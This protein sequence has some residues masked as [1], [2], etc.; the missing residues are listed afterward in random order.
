MDYV[1][2]AVVGAGVLGCFAARALA[3]YDLRIA[4]FEERE[5]VCTGITRANTGIV[6]TGCDAR[7]GTRKARL[8]VE[9][10]RDFGALCETLG[11]R[12]S[13]CGSLMAAFGPRGAARLSRK[14][15]QGQESGVPG[16]RLL[17]P[18]EVYEMEPLLGGGVTAA[19]YAPG[20]GVVEP[21]E[22]GIA[23][24]ENARDNGVDFRFSEKIAHIERAAGGGF[25]LETDRRTCAAR[26][27][28]NC[29]GL[30]AD[31]VRELTEVP[32]IRI[33][34]TAGDYLVL[35][36]DLAGL[37]RHVVFHE[38][39]EGKGLTLVPT[40]DG[41]I[42]AGPTER[43]AGE[44]WASSPEGLE[45]LAGLCA[46][47]APSLPLERVIRSFAALRPNPRHVRRENGVWTADPRA[48]HDFT[49][50][51]EA[52]LI[53]LLG[54]KTP[55]LTCAHLL[56]EIAAKAAARFLGGP[57]RNPGF[58][59][60]RT[61]PPRLRGMPEEERAALVRREPDY[62][63]I[64]CRC[65]EV[66]RGEILEAVRRGAVTVDGVKRRTGAGLGRC[67]GGRCMQSVLEIIAAERG[68]SPA[69]VCRDAPGSAVLTGDDGRV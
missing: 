59:P 23:A 64:L 57:G 20:T 29:A 69:Q 41:A 6:Y 62:G 55:G 33:F 56:G 2:V 45:E 26:A 9:A 1:D 31:A 10:N 7:P 48:V 16:L 47:V 60:R 65:R 11:V 52:G 22:L 46:R 32:A 5:D 68:V 14:L 38:G 66:S 49:V 19:L 51:E 53:S 67:Q 21:W 44:D 4:V 25:R 24:F 58:N 12:F 39:E 3:A 28:V 17:E 18:A 27:V 50:L 42:L 8:C 15:S 13:R 54:I 30:R 43:E 36:Q 61:P 40:V 37:L 63:E 34:P 35:D